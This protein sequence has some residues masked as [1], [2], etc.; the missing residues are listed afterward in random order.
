MYWKHKLLWFAQMVFLLLAFEYFKKLYFT[1]TRWL[2]MDMDFQVA[3]HSQPFHEKQKIT[4]II[5]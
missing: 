3:K 1:I 4:L 2:L 5:K